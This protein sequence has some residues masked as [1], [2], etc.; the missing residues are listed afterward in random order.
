MAVRRG[1][2]NTRTGQERL[3]RQFLPKCTFS[4]GIVAMALIAMSFLAGML[5]YHSIAVLG[6]WVNRRIRRWAGMP[7]EYLAQAMFRR[8][9]GL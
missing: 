5:S 6:G 3:P 2:V 1:L 4:V 9:A 7:A 8:D